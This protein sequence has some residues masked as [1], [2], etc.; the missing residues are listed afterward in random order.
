MSCCNPFI[1]TPR[2]HARPVVLSPH[3]L[4]AP[5]QRDCGSAPITAGTKQ[6]LQRAPRPS[7]GAAAGCQHVRGMPPQPPPLPPRLL[8]RPQ[9]RHRR[10]RCPAPPGPPARSSLHGSTAPGGRGCG[11][12]RLGTHRASQGAGRG[13]DRRQA[14]HGQAPGR[15]HDARVAGDLQRAR[16]ALAV[17]ARMRSRAGRKAHAAMT[18]GHC[19]VQRMRLGGARATRRMS[20]TKAAGRQHSQASDVS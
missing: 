17:R 8:V 18:M 13:E 6:C 14:Q 9:C 7:P 2:L 15:E 11:G 1:V 16:A 19:L 12:A 3:P 5:P 20:P 4:H 10:G